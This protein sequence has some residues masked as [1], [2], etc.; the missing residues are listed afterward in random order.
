MRKNHSIEPFPANI[1]RNHFASWLSGFTDGEGCFHLGTYR[2]KSA[3]NCLVAASHFEI[4]L[5]ADDSKAIKLIQSFLECGNITPRKA[6]KKIK[7]AKPGVMFRIYKVA[8][9]VSKLIPHFENFPLFAKKKRDFIL[10]KEGV[11]MQ[12]E[13]KNRGRRFKSG[14]GRMPQWTKEEF[15]RFLD[16]V[17][18][19]DNTRQYDS[20][21]EISLPSPITIK[22]IRLW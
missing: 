15:A 11:L 18:T 9:L 3:N 20:S 8:D 13:I 2:V 4:S 21:F 14:G 6:P 12:A 17:A 16:L 1:D 7:N 10:W 22:E 5:R 19:L